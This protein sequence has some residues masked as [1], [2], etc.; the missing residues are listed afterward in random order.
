MCHNRK[1]LLS[2]THYMFLISTTIF[3]QSYNTHLLNCLQDPI[4]AIDATTYAYFS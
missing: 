1:R 3:S 2:T 4:Y